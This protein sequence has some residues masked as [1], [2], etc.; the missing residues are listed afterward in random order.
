M[1][2]YD[3][4]CEK[5][6]EGILKNMSKSFRNG[7]EVVIDSIKIGEKETEGLKLVSHRK[8]TE[9]IVA[10]VLAL[11]P[12]YKKIYLKSD[13]LEG[14]IQ[15][16]ALKY[17]KAYRNSPV[18]EA[19]ETKEESEKAQKTESME[20]DNEEKKPENIFYVLIRNVDVELLKDIPHIEKN[21]MTVVFRELMDKD[22]ESVKSQIITNNKME[23]FGLTVDE[24]YKIACKNT[25][26]L[27]PAEVKKISQSEDGE[28]IGYMV[29]NTAKVFGAGTLLYEDEHNP[30]QALAQETAKDLMII[31]CGSDEVFAIPMKTIDEFSMKEYEEFINMYSHMTGKAAISDNVFV[32]KREENKIDFNHKAPRANTKAIM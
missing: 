28:V 29:T 27:F 10:P 30:I 20:L 19:E 5:V 14:V 17:E 21:G 18:K 7:Y 16:I 4:F 8:E 24:M 12:A 23:K 6:K 15:D 13:D 26:V 3:E 22:E 11:E 2:G 31:P 1:I 25:P 9:N 32:Y